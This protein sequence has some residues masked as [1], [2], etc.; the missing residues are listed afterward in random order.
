MTGKMID[1]HLHTPL[2][3][4]AV[5]SLEEYV[6]EA[7]RKG[8]AEIGFAD[9]FPLGLLD[10]VPEEPVTMKPEE[11][12]GYLHE[13]REVSRRSDIPVKLGMEVD[14]LPGKTG[15]AAEILQQCGLDYII[16]SVHFMDGWDF[17]HPHFAGGFK[18]QSLESVY[19][20]YFSLVREACYSGLFDIIGHID[21]VKK[22]GYCPGNEILI[23]L[24]QETARVLKDTGMVLEVNTAGLAAPVKEIYPGESLLQICLQEGVAVTLGS[25]AHSPSQVG[26][27]FSEARKMLYK[28]GLKTVSAFSQRERYPVSI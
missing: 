28:M 12:E 24:Y 7:R 13:V 21:V 8:L 17:T 19:R 6:E 20:R 4:H 18:I 3:R 25:D 23:S 9:H 2:C 10:F 22:F 1:Y 16:G 5:G 15:K 11:L 26:R 27:Y 14:Y